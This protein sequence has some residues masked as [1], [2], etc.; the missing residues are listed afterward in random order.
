MIPYPQESDGQGFSQVHRESLSLFM[1]STDSP[2][3]LQGTPE[4]GTFSDSFPS[5]T[6]RDTR[7]VLHSTLLTAKA[8]KDL[9]WWDSQVAKS[10][11]AQIQP[12][13]TTVCYRV[14]CFKHWMGGSRSECQDRGVMVNPGSP[15]SHQQ[16]LSFWQ[17]SWP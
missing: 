10:S 8:Q 6:G 12:P 17:H 14:R 5:V 11:S 4:N 1:G 7:K 15:L 13:V 3:T 9:Q 16:L 2:T